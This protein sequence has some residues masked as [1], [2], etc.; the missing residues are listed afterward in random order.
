MRNKNIL[1]IGYGDVGKSLEKVEKDAGNIV[2]INDKFKKDNA[3]NG[4]KFD[5]IHICY[6]YYD[7]FISATIGHILFYTSD[8]YIIHSTI[9]VGV[10]DRLISTTKKQIVHS[11]V[12]GCHGKIFI[13]LKTFVKYIGGKAKI[14]K[15]AG[16]HL[17][18]IGIK[19]EILKSAKTT[20]L[21]KLLSTAYYGWNILFAKEAKEFCKLYG[22]DFNEVY[23]NPNK[24]YNKGYGDL[25]MENVIRPILTPPKGKIGGTCVSQNIE[26]FDN[27]PL[28][29][30]FK[31][32]N[33]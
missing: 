14:A 10:T 9:P 30:I 23:T 3:K 4:H 28:K 32:M 5:V 24:T 7:S 8:L 33:K 25:S 17:E 20:E 21:L 31:R 16:K 11:P 15:Q 1:I 2:E 27:L 22:L 13:G 26:L 29:D 6:P 18:N 19:T 12:R